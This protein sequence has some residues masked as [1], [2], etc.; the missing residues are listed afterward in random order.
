MAF[1]KYPYT[2]QH[3]INLDW[4][5]GQFKNLK[6]LVEDLKK[7]VINAPDATTATAGQ[8]PIADGQ[9]GWAWGLAPVQDGSLTENKFSDALKLKTIKDYVTPEMFGAVGD[10]VTDDSVSFQSAIN[11]NRPVF[12][13]KT[14][15]IDGVNLIT[16]TVVYGH[17]TIIQKTAQSPAF[18][19]ENTNNVIITGVRFVSK[20]G[21]FEERTNGAFLFS[22]CSNV[23]IYNVDCDSQADRNFVFN[24]C[25]NVCVHDSQSTGI[26]TFLTFFNSPKSG[27]YNCIYNC[28]GN[29]IGH[30][31]DFYA[32]YNT[33]IDGIFAYNICGYSCDSGLIQFTANQSQNCDLINYNVHDIHSYNGGTALKFDGVS[34]AKFDRCSAVN[35]TYAFSCLG[36]STTRPNDVLITGCYVKN[37]SVNNVIIGTDDTINNLIIEGSYFED[38]LYISAGRCAND[39]IVKN[40]IFKVGTSIAFGQSTSTAKNIV[41]EDNQIFGTGTVVTYPRNAQ[42]NYYFKNNRVCLP[43]DTGIITILYVGNKLIFSGNEFN[44]TQLPKTFRVTIPN[45][46]TST[47]VK[48]F[49]YGNMVNNDFM[50]MATSG[51]SPHTETTYAT[52]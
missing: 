17:G 1:H 4:F 42:E 43:I 50:S 52:A 28:D 16:G 37:M 31:F 5:L 34:F 26:G 27:A 30:G 12:L 51:G 25:E 7:I 3:E 14:Y 36:I 47:S 46:N 19:S 49:H 44:V 18:V 41:F 20:T 35:S 38:C 15:L 13:E 48:V 21:A 24:G 2:D 11:S 10:G 23:N 33:V 39:Y 32:D 45:G 40:N 22:G 9:G 6:K 29:A 8:A